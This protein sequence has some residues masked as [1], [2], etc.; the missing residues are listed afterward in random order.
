MPAAYTGAAT[1]AARNTRG[2]VLLP[3][4]NR[5]VNQSRRFRWLGVV[6]HGRDLP[7]A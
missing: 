3:P 6:R 2:F 4:V 1:L 5:S 7:A